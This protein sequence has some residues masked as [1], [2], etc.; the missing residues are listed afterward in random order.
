M[1]AGTSDCRRLHRNCKSL[2]NKLF[3]GAKCGFSGAA[4]VEMARFARQLPL[5][6]AAKVPIYGSGASF[7]SE[8]HVLLAQF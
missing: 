6:F 1:R 3:Q 7:E 2:F 4:V 8:K 5:N